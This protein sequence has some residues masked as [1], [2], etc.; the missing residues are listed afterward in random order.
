MPECTERK[1]DFYFRTCLQSTDTTVYHLPAGY[2]A[3]A[4]PQ[5]V[6]RNC[7]YASYSTNYIFNQEK[8]ELS[9]IAKVTLK[10]NKIPA[11][12]FKEVKAFFDQVISDDNQKLVIKKN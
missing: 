9:T 8:N 6:E 10:Q 5:P 3:D 12:S 1:T 11:E 4:L 2:V 7:K